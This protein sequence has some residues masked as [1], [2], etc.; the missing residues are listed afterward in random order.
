MTN[1]DKSQARE[2]AVKFLYQCEAEKIFY[3]SDSH[4]NGFVTHFGVKEEVRAYAKKLVKACLDK[5]PDVDKA[6]SMASASWQMNR[7]AATDRAIL[8]LATTEVM[9]G[10]VPK[11]VV[12]NEAIELAKRFGSENSGAFVN[13]VLDA[14]AKSRP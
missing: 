8:R 2:N 3:F 13:G 11:K 5:L 6:I 10:E 1:Q 4:Y 9:L 12:I 7:L 14:I